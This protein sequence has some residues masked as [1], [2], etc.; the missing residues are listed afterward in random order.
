MNTWFRRQA[1]HA[2]VMAAGAGGFGCGARTAAS[3]LGV[4]ASTPSPVATSTTS[5]SDVRI[6]GTVHLS[7]THNPPVNGGVVYVDDAPKRPGVATTATID[8]DHKVFTPLIAVITGGGT[9]TFRNKDA[10]TH[11]VFS[12]DLTQWDTGYLRKN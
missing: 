8:V 4:P 3:P 12:P 10:L 9:V 6:A 11:H 7:S 1:M 2:L 5:L